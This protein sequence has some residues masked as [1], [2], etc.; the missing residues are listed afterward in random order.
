MAGAKDLVHGEICSSY[1]ANVAKKRA[2]ANVIHNLKDTDGVMHSN[3]EGLLHSA[4][5]LYESLYA[6]RPT[7]DAAMKRYSNAFLI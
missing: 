6:R 4:T 1:F 5:Q 7:E 2:E 3:P